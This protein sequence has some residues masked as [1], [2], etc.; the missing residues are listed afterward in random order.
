MGIELNI[1]PA[2]HTEGTQPDPR[3][4]K[5]AATLLGVFTIADTVE[6]GMA[7]VDSRAS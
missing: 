1:P 7:K 4:R 3:F 5:I 2:S 6:G